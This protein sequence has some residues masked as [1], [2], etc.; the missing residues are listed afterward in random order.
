MASPTPTTKL[1]AVNVMLGTINESP[2]NTIEGSQT[3]DVVNAKNI[4]DEVSKSV[5]T[6]GW[7]FN[8]EYDYPLTPDGDNYLK[9]PANTLRVDITSP[10]TVD[11]VM[12]G[13]KMYDRKN[14][15][16]AF[17]G[18]ST[19]Y[20]TL[21]LALDFEELPEAA[22]RYITV[23]AARIFQKRMVGSETLDGFTEDEE[24]LAYAA[25]LHAESDTADYSIFDNYEIA[26]IVQRGPFGGYVK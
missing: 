6:K 17:T 26:K 9:P 2:V 7:H 1:E 20:C 13:T 21:V 10:T 8:S 25:F 16:Y 24:K 23:K 18:A 19:Y 4:L 12:R 22:R 15:T 14:H 11:A 3:A 5:Q